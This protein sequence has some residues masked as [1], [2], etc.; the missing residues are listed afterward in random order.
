M[1]EQMRVILSLE[2]FLEED[3][4]FPKW[5]CDLEKVT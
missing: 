5:D 1:T 2:C 3:T 4:A